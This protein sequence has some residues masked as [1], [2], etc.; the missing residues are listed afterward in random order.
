[1]DVLKK[2]QLEIE[3]LEAWLESNVIE[4]LSEKAEVAVQSAIVIEP[5]SSS[6]YNVLYKSH[7]VNF[8]NEKRI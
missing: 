6:E 3:Y 5:P 2:M 1:M 8:R 7:C 4:P